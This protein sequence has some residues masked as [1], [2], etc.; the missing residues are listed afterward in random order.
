M[1]KAWQAAALDLGVVFESP[2]TFRDSTGREFT[3]AGLLP[4]F[5]GPKGVLIFS[6]EDLEPYEEWDRAYEVANEQK[7]YQSGLNPRYY[8]KY[9]REGFMETLND[10][11]WFGPEGEQPPWFDG[12]IRAHGGRR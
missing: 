6:R 8:E 2:Y 5:G 1:A 9:N 4:H 11:G 12:A 10:W 7:Y 3:C